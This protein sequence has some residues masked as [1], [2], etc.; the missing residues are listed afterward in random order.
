VTF[1]LP[2]KVFETPERVIMPDLSC[3]VEP[4]GVEAANLQGV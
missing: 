4:P 2:S 3:H 1:L